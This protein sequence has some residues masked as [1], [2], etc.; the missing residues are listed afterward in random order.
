M[1]D[2]CT[3][4]FATQVCAPGGLLHDRA[5]LVPLILQCHPLLPLFDAHGCMEAVELTADPCH[6][7]QSPGD[8]QVRRGFLCP[9]RQTLNLTSICL[10]NWHGHLRMKAEPPASVAFDH[11]QSM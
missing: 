3:W 1:Y 7:N 8:S 4:V 2:K 11:S 9:S 5:P 10:G 6:P